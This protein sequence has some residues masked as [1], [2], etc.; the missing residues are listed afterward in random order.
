VTVVAHDGEVAQPRLGSD[1]CDLWWLSNDE[2]GTYEA[3]RPR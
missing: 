2:E 1:E 3:G